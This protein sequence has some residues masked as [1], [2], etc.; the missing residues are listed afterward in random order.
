MK[1]IIF[2]MLFLCSNLVFSKQVNLCSKL[3]CV[4]DDFKKKNFITYY[5]ILN[6]TLIDAKGCKDNKKFDNVLEFTGKITRVGPRERMAKFIENEFI[7]NPSCIL[8]AIRRI[9]QDARHH[10][11]LYL[12]KPNNFNEK[13]INLILD[14][15]KK[16]YPNEIQFIIKEKQL[17]NKKVK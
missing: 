9:S 5:T 15:Y 3:E 8:S 13:K 7:K 11:L 6:K 1:V 10:T 17:L 16:K 14:E 12:V 4:D 2:T